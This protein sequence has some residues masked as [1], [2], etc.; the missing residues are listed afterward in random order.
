MEWNKEVLEPFDTLVAAISGGADSMALLDLLAQHCQDKHVVVAHFDHRLR[1]ESSQQAQSLMAYASGRGFPFV[2]KMWDAPERAEAAA[3]DARYRFLNEIADQYP[4]SAIVTAHHFDDQMETFFLKLVRASTLN[5][6]SAMA[7]RA[8]FKGRSPI[9]RP[10]LMQEKKTLEDYVRA[11]GLPVFEDPSNM[12]LSYERN[13][14]RNVLLK[15]VR[16]KYPQFP[17]QMRHIL[18]DIRAADRL[19][20]VYSENWLEELCSFDRKRISLSIDVYSKWSNYQQRL[21]L[22]YLAERLITQ[23]N[24][25]LSRQQVEDISSLLTDPFRPQA[26]LSLPNDWT[27]EKSYQVAYIKKD[28]RVMKERLTHPIHLNGPVQA[29]LPEGKVLLSV[30]R[31][32]EDDEALDLMGKTCLFPIESLGNLTV[33]HRENGDIIRFSS[34]GRTPFHQKVARF[35]INTKV[36]NDQRESYLLVLNEKNTVIGLLG[37]M[38]TDKQLASDHR[39]LQLKVYKEDS[40]D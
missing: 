10:L 38:T 36:P 7:L 4:N 24:L 30:E 2:M 15:Q 19:L 17:E 14:W 21:A 28:A 40:H 29:P 25:T 39:Y 16:E 20:R 9:V 31:E 13:W 8:D 23:Y 35:F 26:R 37:L 33:R 12:D 1:S 32:L 5:G 22:M 34:P 18:F 27:F 6:L 11:K 3:R